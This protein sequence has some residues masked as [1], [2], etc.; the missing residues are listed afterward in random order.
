MSYFSWLPQELID[1]ILDFLINDA[2]SLKA[3]SLVCRSFLYR[4]R[5]HLFWRFRITGTRSF[6][7]LHEMFRKSPQIPHQIRQLT[8]HN[9]TGDRVRDSEHLSPVISSFSCL[10][11]IIFFNIK[12]T[13]LP[14]ASRDALSSHAFQTISLHTDMTTSDLRS[15][16]SSSHDSLHRLELYKTQ[17]TGSFRRS[18]GSS[19][20]IRI[21]S[22]YYVP[23]CYELFSQTLPSFLSLGHLHTPHVLLPDLSSARCLQKV[24]REQFCSLQ[25]LGVT[26]P[27]KFSDLE[28]LNSSHCLPI[29]GLLS[30]IVEMWDFHDRPIDQHLQWWIENIRQCSVIERVTFRLP[31]Y[32]Y[33]SDYSAWK[34]L[35]SY[36]SEGGSN[37]CLKDVVIDLGANWSMSPVVEPAKLAMESQFTDKRVR[38]VVTD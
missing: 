14:Q 25:H 13:L 26:R 38:V 20:R 37:P 5:V 9:V 33:L 6:S 31:L 19:P 7:E 24:L 17:V 8:L 21:L 29:S 30:L 35:D 18:V 34:I 23:L 12:W 10:Q 2:R 4:T 32:D 1:Y 11:T 28:R 22:L 3:S 15:L 27:P 16:V 36:L